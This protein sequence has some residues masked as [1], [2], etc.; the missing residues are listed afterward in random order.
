MQCLLLALTDESGWQTMSK[1][2][3]EP[4]LAAVG[5]YA[6]ALKTAARDGRP[7]AGRRMPAPH[8]ATRRAY[9]P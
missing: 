4:G 6:Q 7:V 3:Q 8:R 5:A 9:R 2:E 1:T